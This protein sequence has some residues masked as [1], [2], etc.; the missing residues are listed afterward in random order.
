M[1]DSKMNTAMTTSS[2]SRP[3][4]LVRLDPGCLQELAAQKKKHNDRQTDIDGG[5]DDEGRCQA[6]HRCDGF[7]RPHDTV[8]DP[9]L[10]AQFSNNPSGFNG[11]KSQRSHGDNRAQ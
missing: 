1:S 2:T 7:M 8:N 4:W 6:V 9:R 11:H 10:P 3:R 5:E